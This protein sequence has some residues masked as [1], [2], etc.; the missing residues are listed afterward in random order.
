M[1]TYVK[2]LKDILAK[3]KRLGEYKTTALPK[4]CSAIIQNKVP[5]TLKDPGA[6]F[7]A[8]ALSGLG[9]SINLMPLSIY[10]KLGLGEIKPTSVTL[11]LADLSLTYPRG[12]YL[13]TTRALID[14]EKGELTLRVQDQKVTFNIYRALIFPNDSDEC[15]VVSAINSVTSE[16][17]I[18]NHPKYPL[19]ASLVANSKRDDDELLEYVNMLDASSWILRA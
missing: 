11:Q 8:K 14:V 13:H 1:P 3:K 12:D 6:L 17:F 7:F 16:V 15:F 19:K 18:E 10:R 4:E 5:L 9:A 2:F